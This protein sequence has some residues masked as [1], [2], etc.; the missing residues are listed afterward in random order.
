MEVAPATVLMAA[1]ADVLVAVVLQAALVQVLLVVQIPHALENVKA[2][3]TLNAQDVK[4]VVKGLAVE[5][6]AVTALTT[7]AL[8]VPMMLINNK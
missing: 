4:M 1:E 7:A 6:A 3:A 5:D 8:L 2:L